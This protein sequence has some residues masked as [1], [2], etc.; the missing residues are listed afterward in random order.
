MNK[1][2]PLLG[3]APFRIFILK[4]LVYSRHVFAYAHICTFVTIR[5]IWDSGPGLAL[6]PICDMFKFYRNKSMAPT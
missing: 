1:N 4:I 5:K 3:H 2:I 6:A